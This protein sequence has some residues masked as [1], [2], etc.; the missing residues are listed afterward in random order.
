MTSA[1]LSDGHGLLLVGVLLSQL[2]LLLQKFHT[3]P[4]QPLL[5][6]FFQQDNNLRVVFA[7]EH[8]EVLL[9]KPCNQASFRKA[10]RYRARLTCDSC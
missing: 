8:S 3:Q 1:M 6:L 4:G 9:Q 7:T 5:S 2:Q 10:C